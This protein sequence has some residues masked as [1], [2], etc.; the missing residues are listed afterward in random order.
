MPPVRSTGSRPKPAVTS[1]PASQTPSTGAATAG[2]PA[3]PAKPAATSATDAFK[4]VVAQVG[5]AIKTAGPGPYEMI[6]G[7]YPDAVSLPAVLS[8]LGTTPEGQ[9]A[10][11]NLLAGLKAKTG[12]TMPPEVQAALLSNP[13]GA[14]TALELTPRQLSQGVL[15]LNA[16]YQA[17]KIPPQTPTPNLLP[18]S[19]DL[20]TVDQVD[21]PRPQSTMKQVAPG[22]FQGDLPSSTPDAQVKQNRVMAEVFSRLSTDV[23]AAD[24]SKFSVTYNGQ[25]YSRLDDF[26]G[27]LKADGYDVKVSFQ[28]RIANF[29]DL[30]TPVPGT[31]PQQWL[32]VPAPLMVKTG[33]K[34]ASG[35]QAIVPASHSEMIISVRSGPNTKGPKLD[36]DLRYFQGDDGT[37]FFPDNVWQTPNWL[38]H[39][40]HAEVTGDDAIKALNVAGTLGDVIDQ[41]AKKLNLYADGYGVTGV[42]NDSVAIVQQAVLGH[43]EQYPLMMHEELLMGELKKRLAQPAGTGPDAAMYQTLSD[44]ISK[45]P[46]DI[47]PNASAKARA[48]ASLPWVDGKEPFQSTIGA[49]KILSQ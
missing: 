11:N 24:G 25:S 31:S 4:G 5:T 45:V 17:G 49:R 1:K 8:K 36:S 42:C 9:A 48:L 22:L 3:T 47:K 44:A 27:A 6:P 38:G 35:N 43:I 16:A 10:V 39:V 15:A 18:Q 41:T 7:R 19:F 30:K 34:D 13:S 46:S 26:L 40:T 32:D 2:T 28:A 21:A 20:S 14:T 33:V 12:I 37:G 29:A 23:S